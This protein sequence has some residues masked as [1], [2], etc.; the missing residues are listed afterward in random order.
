MG[1]SCDGFIGRLVRY[2]MVCLADSDETPQTNT[3]KG[4]YALCPEV[5]IQLELLLL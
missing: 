4:E 2:L 5:V 3:I 1:D